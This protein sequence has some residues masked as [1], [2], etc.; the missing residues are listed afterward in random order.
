MTVISSLVPGHLKVSSENYEF[1]SRLILPTLILEKFR[2][3]KNPENHW[4]TGVET[5]DFWIRIF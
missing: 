4:G 3:K 5:L 1:V 2:G